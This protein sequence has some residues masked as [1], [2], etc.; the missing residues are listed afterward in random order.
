[1]A[2]M[3][4][5]G[6]DGRDGRAMGGVPV[7]S[8]TVCGLVTVSSTSVELMADAGGSR[9]AGRRRL[10]VQPTDGAIWI[11]PIPGTAAVKQSNTLKYAS[12]SIVEFFFPDDGD[13]VAIN[14]I[15]DSVDVKV[16]CWEQTG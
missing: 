5:A 15:Y 13:D 16:M 9:L 2:L 7:L 8:D 11:C 1:M 3:Q 12:G 14:A 10:I 4:L 6:R